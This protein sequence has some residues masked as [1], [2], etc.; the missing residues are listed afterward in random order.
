[1]SNEVKFNQEL[2]DMASASMSKEDLEDFERKGEELYNAEFSTDLDDT[3]T[4]AVAYVNEAL[5]SGMH[6]SYLNEDER[7][8]MVNVYGKEWF[9]R[10]GYE[11]ELL[12]DLT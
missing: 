8:L 3:K 7:D 4:L 11:S 2:Y 6:P 9:K 1:M 10:Y 12:D 5:K